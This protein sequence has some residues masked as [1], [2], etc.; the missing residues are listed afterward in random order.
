MPFERQPRSPVQTI[1]DILDNIAAIRGFVAGLDFNAFLADRRTLYAVTRALE[2]ISES[3]R[4]LPD[5]LKG[6]HTHI[7]WRGIAAAGNIY[8]HAYDGVDNALVWNV[9]VADLQPLETALK[10]ELQRLDG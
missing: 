8:R 1:E 7:D 4:R 6:R 10:E 5:D 2:I 9:I 3:S